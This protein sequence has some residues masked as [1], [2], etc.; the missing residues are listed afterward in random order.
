MKGYMIH[1]LEVLTFGY[2]E[3]IDLRTHYK[4]YTSVR[5]T[6]EICGKMSLGSEHSLT[7]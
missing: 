2:I 7:D 6:S 4:R 5:N 1:S 3:F